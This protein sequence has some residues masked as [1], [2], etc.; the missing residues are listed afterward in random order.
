MKFGSV[1]VNVAVIVWVTAVEKPLLKVQGCTIPDA[2]VAVHKEVAGDVEVSTKSMVPDCGVAAFV[3]SGT[4]AI[5]VVKVTAWL[6]SK[7][8]GVEEGTEVTVLALET[9]WVVVGEVAGA[10]KLVSP[11]YTA[12]TVRDPCDKKKPLQLAF[13]VNWLTVAVHSGTAGAEVV[14]EK[15]TM[16]VG[17]V[18][19]VSAEGLATVA[20]N[21]TT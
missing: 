11:V 13:P 12:V 1:E 9:G 18:G 8:L 15:A 4:G 3:G 20:A 5:D 16:P 6:T 2:T 7:G 21:A 19:P 14:S 17:N 10:L